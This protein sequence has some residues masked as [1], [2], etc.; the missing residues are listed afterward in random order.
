[1]IK[2][3]HTSSKTVVTNYHEQTEVQLQANVL[4][5]VTKY[6]EQASYLDTLI[7]RVEPPFLK[8]WT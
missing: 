1:M 4:L 6:T 8:L 3:L 5:N 2:I 7:Y